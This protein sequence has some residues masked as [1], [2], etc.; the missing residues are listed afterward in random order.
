[1]RKL[2]PKVDGDPSERASSSW[3][4]VS[5]HRTGAHPPRVLQKN[6]CPFNYFLTLKVFD[7]VLSV[8]HPSGEW[9]VL[10]HV[11]STGVTLLPMRW[12]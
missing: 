9:C 4:Q 6:K 3:L 1:M 10:D 7:S 8:L 12:N 2:S 5:K 11:F